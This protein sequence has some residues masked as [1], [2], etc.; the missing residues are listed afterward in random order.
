MNSLSADFQIAN[1]DVPKLLAVAKQSAPV[2][3]VLSAKGQVS[4]TVGDPRVT[5]DFTLEKG[6]LGG[7]PFDS[8][9]GQA[10][11]TAAGVYQATVVVNAGAKRINGTGTLEHSRLSFAVSTNTLQLNQITLVKNQ[12]PDIRG[13]AR[14]RC[15]DSRPACLDADATSECA[16]ARRP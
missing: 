16:C 10:R 14:R 11:S 5:G 6:Q 9:T 2:S 8:V 12:V 7:E 13:T 4:G 15:R 1:A 3:G